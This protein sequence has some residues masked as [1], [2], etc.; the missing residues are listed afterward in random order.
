MVQQNTVFFIVKH[1]L[2]QRRRACTAAA[3]VL[4]SQEVDVGRNFIVR[5]PFVATIFYRQIAHHRV[6]SFANEDEQRYGEPGKRNLD[7]SLI[8]I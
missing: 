8:H 5:D 3:T 4:L 2:L 6:Q 1:C 7:L